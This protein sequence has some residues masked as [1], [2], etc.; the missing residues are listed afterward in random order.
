MSA[1]PR[2]WA[3]SCWVRGPE[4]VSPDSGRPSVD[5][6]AVQTINDERTSNA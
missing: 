1:S 5:L 4:R 6:G 3:A 2:P